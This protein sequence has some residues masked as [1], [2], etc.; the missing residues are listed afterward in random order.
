VL[1]VAAVGVTTLAR[2]GRR[3][4]RAGERPV[5]DGDPLDPSKPEYRDK[6]AVEEIRS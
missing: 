2:V 3:P 4:P 1:L 6:D 5:P